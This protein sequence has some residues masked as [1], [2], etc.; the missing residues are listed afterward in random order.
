MKKDLLRVT[1]LSREDLDWILRTTKVLKE[2]NKKGNCTDILTGKVLG[3]FFK[4]HL[5]EPEYHLK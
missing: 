5:Q 2:E 4:N 3:C 1:D